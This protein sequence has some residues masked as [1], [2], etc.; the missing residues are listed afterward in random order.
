MCCSY[1]AF[2]FLSCFMS[3]CALLLFPAGT[4]DEGCQCQGKGDDAGHLGGFEDAQHQL[5]VVPPQVLKAETSGGVEHDIEGK[6]LS[7]G[8]GKG[9][10]QEQEAEDE[11]IQLAF[12]DFGRPQGLCSVGVVGKGGLGI[13]DA[14]ASA[15][16][17]PKGIA[18][19]QVGAASQ[20]LAE[21]DGRGA[22]IHHSQDIDFVLAA[23]QDAGDDTQDNAS[24]DCHAPLPHV[25]DFRQVVLVIIP[26]KEE[27]VPEPCP[28]K[29]AQAAV[30]ADICHM[31]M[32]A[33]VLPGEEIRHAGG[34]DDADA[35]HQ[36]VG[37]D[38][39]ISYIK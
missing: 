27:H 8:V 7:F 25:E 18:V 34:D 14:E 12:P 38:G 2:V 11:K 20:P 31:L 26:V 29:A 1:A 6:G 9:A 22:D 28:Q 15:G 33:S 35:Q 21:D 19:Q 37:P 39:E 3:F 17:C 4:V 13:E 32:V 24:L 10:V 5:R 30:D 16:R 36:P 23:V